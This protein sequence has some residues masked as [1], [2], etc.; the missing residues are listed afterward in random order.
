[1][2]LDRLLTEHNHDWNR[3]MPAYEQS[4]KPNGDAV[5]DLALANFIEMRDLVGQPAFLLRKKIEAR[6]SE[7]H[8][9]KWT[10]LYT[11][12]TFSET[13]YSVALHEG[14]RQDSIMEQ[15]MAMPDIESKW[16]SAEVENLMLELLG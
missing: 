14:K 9:E 13:P 7:R 11:M 3:I 15:V 16:D 2:D 5:A 8:P 10:P 12:V 1:V 4:R 6:F